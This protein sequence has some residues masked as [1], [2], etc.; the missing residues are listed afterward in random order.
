MNYSSRHWSYRKKDKDY[1]KLLVKEH[2]KRKIEFNVPVKL[3][4]TFGF[5]GKVLDCTNC[6][7]MAK[8]IEDCLVLNNV[9]ID[10]NPQ[11]V[12]S[13]EIKST[14]SEEDE[15]LLTIEEV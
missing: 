9:L 13:V 11:Y 8:L 15:C 14:K 7:Y 2:I 1:Y 10:D 6:F 3:T 4:F 5:K 12:K